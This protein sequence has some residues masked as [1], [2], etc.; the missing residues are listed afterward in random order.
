MRMC[1]CSGHDVH[2]IERWVTDGQLHRI[3]SPDITAYAEKV[4]DVYDEVPC[5]KCLGC[6]LDYA[7]DWSNR[8]LM[9]MESYPDDPAYFLTLTYDNDHCPVCVDPYTGIPHATLRYRDVQLFLKRLRKHYPNENI[10][11][12]CSGEYGTTTLRPHYH[13]ILIGH[14]FSD[15]DVHKLD[16]RG[17]TLFTS[18]ELQRFWKNGFCSIGYATKESAGYVARYNMKAFGN[19]DIKQL[20]EITC[21]EKPRMRGSRRPALGRQFILDHADDFMKYGSVWISTE[22]GGVS[23]PLP[24]YGQALL[25]D[26]ELFAFYKADQRVKLEA[27][28]TNIDLSTDLNWYS[29]LELQ[30]ENKKLQTKG[31]KRNGI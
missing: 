29:Y 20:C 5:G 13:M 30:G 31:L 19:E 28:K 25:K 27:H 2:H 24:R 3:R 10:R 6:S 14:A 8:C 4:Y 26:H 23:V 9:E 7:R 18:Q 15:L 22:K 17:Y 12:L 21:I 11:F 16:P 1:Y